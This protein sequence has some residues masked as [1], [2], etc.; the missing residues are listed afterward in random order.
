M[1][2][3]GTHVAVYIREHRFVE[4]TNQPVQGVASLRVY[5]KGGEKY[6]FKGAVRLERLESS[7]QFRISFHGH[8]IAQDGAVDPN[9]RAGVVNLPILSAIEDWNVALEHTPLCILVRLS[10]DGVKKDG[11]SVA[12]LQLAFPSDLQLR[13]AQAVS[14]YDAL[15]GSNRERRRLL[16]TFHAWCNIIMTIARVVSSIQS[17]MTYFVVQPVISY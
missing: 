9:A 11:S 13:V 2:P 5:L 17:T 3:T 12:K 6:R 10:F 4:V 14:F 15:I 1:S 8:E 7:P 16:A